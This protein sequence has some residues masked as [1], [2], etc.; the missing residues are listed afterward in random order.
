MNNT[1]SIGL[2]VYAHI[3]EIIRA[4]SDLYHMNAETTHHTIMNNSS[5]WF[6]SNQGK[7]LFVDYQ[8]L[9]KCNRM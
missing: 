5:H 2:D 1:K 9:F 4:I 3:R 7:R 6:G 8:V